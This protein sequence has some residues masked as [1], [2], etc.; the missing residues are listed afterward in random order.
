MKAIIPNVFWLAVSAMV[1]YTIVNPQSG[2]G[3]IA[4]LAIW[5]VAIVAVF[6]SLLVLSVVAYIAR[7][8]NQEHI[9]KAREAVI[10]KKRSA[11]HKA[12]GWAK[13]VI[14]A[15]LCAYTGMI[16]TGIAYIVAWSSV[17][18]VMFLSRSMLDDLPA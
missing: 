11:L 7:S 9:A 8:G 1:A 18:A 3:N 2:F 5:C 15:S 14:M 13:L 4:A 12:I 16:V 10:G 17:S 6:M